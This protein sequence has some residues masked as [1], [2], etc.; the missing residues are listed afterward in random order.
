MSEKKNTV[1]RILKGDISAIKEGFGSNDTALRIIAIIN[2]TKLN[3]KDKEVI[4]RIKIL[5][6]DNSYLRICA[7]TVGEFA[8]ASLHLQGIINYSGNNLS[9]KKL[10]DSKFDF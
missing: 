1:N 5:T 9:I 10:I 6:E 3:I 4:E 2:S 7:F 8:T